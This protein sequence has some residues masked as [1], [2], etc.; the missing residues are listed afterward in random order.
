[1]S[2]V[3]EKL[4]PKAP[5]VD[6]V[7]ITTTKTSLSKFIDE[8]ASS[9]TISL[10]E[11]LRPKT[12]ILS[13]P[14]K[15]SVLT[16]REF[17]DKISDITLSI[18]N[19]KFSGKDFL[20]SIRNNPICRVKCMNFHNLDC[21]LNDKNLEND[22]NFVVEDFFKALDRVIRRSINNENT[23]VEYVQKKLKSLLINVLPQNFE[24]RASQIRELAIDTEDLLQNAVDQ[25]FKKAVE[26]PK[27]CAAY[28]L[29]CKQLSTMEVISENKS[30]TFGQLLL[31]RCQNEVEKQIAHENA[32]VKK[33]KESHEICELKKEKKERE[34]SLILEPGKSIRSIDI[35]R[36]V[37]EL[38]IQDMIGCKMVDVCIK[39]LLNVVSEE[40]LECLCDFLRRVGK[41]LELQ[42]INL[43]GTFKKI[44]TLVVE[45]SSLSPKL[46][47]KLL[48]L[49]ILHDNSWVPPEEN[50]SPKIKKEIA[51]ETEKLIIRL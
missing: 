9:H 27:S 14:S 11:K 36:F 2:V 48:N 43:A 18:D 25:V 21:L 32:L 20:N 15:I 10:G 37:G 23:K 22:L 17:Q 51:P 7:K 29:L 1:M 49:I 39:H 38:F 16:E 34:P 40:N 8:K 45:N 26:E 44:Q 46:R 6:T 47:F 35:I 12:P 41:V 13:T 31:N 42:K 5:S 24:I 19:L 30:V 3:E 28:T 50:F 4:L 33:A